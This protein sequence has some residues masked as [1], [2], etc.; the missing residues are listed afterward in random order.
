MKKRDLASSL[1]LSLSLM[2]AIMLC[3][4]VPTIINVVENHSIEDELQSLALQGQDVA[5]GQ[6]RRFAKIRVIEARAIALMKTHLATPDARDPVTALNADY[7]LAADGTRRSRPGLFDGERHPSGPILQGI[8]GYIRNGR[9]MPPER[10][11]RL[12]AASETLRGMGE[13]LKPELTSLYYFTPQND[14]LIFAPDRPDRLLFYR[15]DAP[16]DVDFQQQSIARVVSPLQNPQREMRCTGLE[17]ASYDSS[18]RTWTTGCMTP[19]DIGGRHVGSWGVSLPLD[20]L[21]A[22]GI[23]SGRPGT[24]IIIVSAKG[25]LIFDAGYTRQSDS[26]TARYLDLARTTNPRLKALGRFLAVPGGRI[27]FAGAIPELRA[28]ASVTEVPTP[29]WRIISLRSQE[30]VMAPA[31]YTA[32]LIILVGLLVC[33]IAIVALRWLVKMRVGRPL[34][35]LTGRAEAVAALSGRKHVVEPTD[36]GPFD[37]IQRLN[38]S[39]DVLETSVSAERRRLQQ[40]FDL[41]ARSIKNYGIFMLDVQGRVVNWNVGAERLT[42]YTAAEILGRHASILLPA[43]GGADVAL[44]VDAAAPVSTAE[45]WRMRRDGSRFW[46]EVLTESV[47]DELGQLI[48]HATIV[49]DITPER[50]QAMRLQESMRLLNFA[51]NAARLGHWRFQ[52][53]DGSIF[54]SPAMYA[55]KGLA[56][57]EAMTQDLVFAGFDRSEVRRFLS[58]CTQLLQMPQEAKLTTWFRHADGRRRDVEVRVFVETDVS[59]EPTAIFGIM[60]DIT[61]ARQAAIDLMAA[62]DAATEAAEARTDLLATMSHEIRTPMTGIIGMLELLQDKGAALPAG[63]SIEGL[64]QSARTMMTVLDDAL[65]HTRLESGNIQFEA[66]PFDLADLVSDTA[67]LFHGIAATRGTSIAVEV[68]RP[69]P[70]LGDPSRLQQIIS[71]LVGNAVKFTDDGVVQI[72]TSNLPNGMTRIMVA[73]TGI[74]IEASRLTGIFDPYRQANSDTARRFGGT[75]LGLAISRRLAR[76]MGGEIEAS[77]IAGEGSRFW[78]DIPFKHAD[79]AQP[80]AAAVPIHL[81]RPDGAAPHILLAEDIE[82]TRQIAEAHLVALGCRVTAVTNG[83]EALA[84][85]TMTT[86]DAMLIDSRMP[87]LDGATTT[88]LARMLPGAAGAIPMLA[89]TAAASGAEGAA[90]QAAGCDAMVAKPFERKRLAT[91]L[92][93]LLDRPIP[94]SP[95]PIAAIREILSALPPGMRER[96]ANS[97]RRDATDSARSLAAALRD[98]DAI[99]AAAA[100]HALAGLGAMIG[101]DELSR[102][103]RFGE[104]LLASLAPQDCIWMGDAIAVCAEGLQATIH[105]ALAVSDNVAAPGPNVEIC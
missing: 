52:I 71:N 90:M 31:R 61:D 55:I 68:T 54:W 34:Q 9:D 48:G 30:Q 46:A 43:D 16:P 14:V 20:E 18:G 64:A 63:M 7:P 35:T 87:V 38:A 24:A 58:L 41:L 45:G 104:A 67:A 93:P 40:S 86:P 75:G 5:V 51:E 89:F 100:L 53:D 12:L 50:D 23:G 8:G 37:E 92:T 56:P 83:A 95:D 25:Q 62:R 85:L 78:V 36:H 97:A 3:L 105:A 70:V 80:E 27:G 96:V 94:Q 49:R 21:F 60:R 91:T 29:G 11:R 10:A 57:G 44:P 77:S 26:K 103:S 66:I 42:G 47:T 69:Q 72:L 1:A 82:A 101:A 2:I 15:R 79:D 99:A 98:H 28:Y 73:D 13:G 65:D 6:E 39:F 32:R 17:P 22:T 74:G 76:A 59:G 88:R 102:L 4:L 81:V 33:L 19:L 84:V